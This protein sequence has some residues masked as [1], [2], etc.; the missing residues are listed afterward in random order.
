M[1]NEKQHNINGNKA[2]MAKT[3]L[4]MLKIHTL[5]FANKS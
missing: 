1:K 4:F 2:V 5:L 3:I